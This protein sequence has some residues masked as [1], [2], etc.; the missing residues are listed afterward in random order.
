MDEDLSLWSWAWWVFWLIGWGFV[1]LWLTWFYEI[2]NDAAWHGAT[3]R[4]QNS[5]LCMSR[6]FNLPN[7]ISG[8][9]CKHLQSLGN[10]NIICI[11]ISEKLSRFWHDLSETD[12]ISSE[13]VPSNSWRVCMYDPCW[14]T[15]WIISVKLK[16][17]QQVVTLVERH[18][19]T[20]GRM[21]RRQVP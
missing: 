6:G 7:E 9:I 17:F 4:K 19:L 16:L 20:N 14:R 21:D 15:R 2:Y 8:T 12:T 13:H 1:L 5:G 11:N 18:I 10:K 3:H